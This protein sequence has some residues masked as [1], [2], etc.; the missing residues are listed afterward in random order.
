MEET[1]K[2]SLTPSSL[3]FL[4]TYP[5]TLR[6]EDF[7]GDSY[8]QISENEIARTVKESPRILGKLRF[9][10]LN[11][12][13]FDFAGPPKTFKDLRQMVNNGTLDCTNGDRIPEF[14]QEW[15]RKYTNKV[16]EDKLRKASPRTEEEGSFAVFPITGKLNNKNVPEII[17]HDTKNCL[18]A[19]EPTSIRLF[20][21]YIARKG[22]IKPGET[23]IDLCAG[24][25]ITSL[26]AGYMSEGQGQIYALD[27]MDQAVATAAHNIDLHGLPNVSV[28][29]SDMFS[30]LGD[31][32]V[33]DKIFINPPFNP[34]EETPETKDMLPEAVHDYG[35]SVLLHL[36][37]QAEKHL[38]PNGK[39]YML[40]EDI[41]VFPNNQ[42]AVEWA[43]QQHNLKQSK[44]KYEIKTLIRVRRA[45]IDNQGNNILIPFVV[46]EITPVS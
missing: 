43:S 42:N 15:T 45:R 38:K 29:K 24:S 34:K 20:N 28:L 35:Y 33:A 19:S 10:I 37:E 7:M 1:E 3:A 13:R 30:A 36:F 31:D 8:T 40:Y 4:A 23:V 44:N 26:I 12:G 18:S 46:Y 9:R 5:P 11:Q 6:M 25:A 41:K 32:V 14:I 21:N 39:I 2:R 22:L 16:A 17:F 27:I